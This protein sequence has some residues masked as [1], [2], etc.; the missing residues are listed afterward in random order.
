MRDAGLLFLLNP[1]KNGGRWS[2]SATCTGVFE[3]LKKS[4]VI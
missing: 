2:E 1:G 4:G 3:G